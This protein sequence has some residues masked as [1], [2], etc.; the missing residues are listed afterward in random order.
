M[1]PV[2]KLYKII[3][4]YGQREVLHID[5]LIIP[6]QK[7][8]A[9]LGP[10]GSGKT[11]LMRIMALLTRNDTGTVD[12][13]GEDIHWGKEQLL[14][15]RRQM[16]MVT[17]T[18]FMFEGSVYANVAYGLKVR[19]KPEREI[20]PAV[21]KSLELLGMSA[22][23]TADARNLSGGERQKVAIAR[24]LAVEPRVLFLDEPTANIDPQS[25]VEIER[26]IQLINRE[27]GTTI[28]LVTHNLFQARRLADEVFFM[29]DG[30][31]VEQGSSQEIFEHP[32]D[33]RTRSFLSGETFF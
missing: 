6:G 23:I 29:W 7:I 31:M 14:K 28:I 25:A 22:F 27:L 2:F 9:I 12:V 11:T 15:L 26:H 17:Q 5:E 1:T 32:Q 18:S 16:T 8:C 20:C 30:K 3:K 24:A 13:L 10:N 21:E 4:R 33:E 19:R